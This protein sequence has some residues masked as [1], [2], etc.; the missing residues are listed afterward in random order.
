[1]DFKQQATSGFVLLRRTVINWADEY[2]GISISLF[3]FVLPIPQQTQ[4]RRTLAGNGR[5]Q[6]PLCGS[7][8]GGH[9]NPLL[10]SFGFL[11]SGQR[12]TA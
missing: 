3:N 8:P 9:E 11:N 6:S 2:H 7:P 10:C 5:R 1:L 12:I 4:S